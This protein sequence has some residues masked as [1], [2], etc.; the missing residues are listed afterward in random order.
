MCEHEVII[1]PK[2][3]IH[4]VHPVNFRQLI[5]LD[6]RVELP[7]RR[8]EDGPTRTNDIFLAERHGPYA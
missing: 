3:V 7:R 4:A 6:E 5:V 1:E 8:V 2:P